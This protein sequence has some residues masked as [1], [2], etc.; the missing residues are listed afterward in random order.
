VKKPIGK[1]PR[2]TRGKEKA[3]RVVIISGLSGSGKTVALR[4]VEDMNFFCVDNLPVSLIDSLVSRISRHPVDRNI[5]IGIDIRE[6]EF[7]PSSDKVLSM[8]R[9]RYRLEVLFLEAE[10]QVLI[11]RFKETRR[12]HPLGGDLEGAIRAEKLRLEPLRQNADRVIDTSSYSP[13]QLRSLITS[14]YASGEG[15]TDLTVTLI[16]F[17]F[18]YGVPQNIDLLFDVRFLPNPYFVP[19]LRNRNGTDRRTAEYVLSDP[20]TKAFMKKVRDLLTFLLPRYR[21]EGRAYLSIAIGCT[22]GNHRSPAIIEEIAGLIKKEN[23][24]VNVIHR[25]MS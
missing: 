16:S 6:K 15:P 8:L 13:H 4:A 10:T 9:D 1:V 17:G 5:A 7:L 20:D 22:G 3:P 11:R 23:L 2:R 24:G 14:I 19:E 25:D 18:K 12:P 21:R